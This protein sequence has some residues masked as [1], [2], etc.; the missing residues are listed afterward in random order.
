MEKLIEDVLEKLKE[1]NLHSAVAR[2][3]IVRTIM[4]EIRSGKG[5]F[6]NMSTID[7]G[8][9][10]VGDRLEEEKWV[11]AICGKPT[12]HI[13]YEYIGSEYNHLGC[14]LKEENI[15][16]ND[17]VYSGDL[18]KQAYTEMTSDGLPE[19]GDSQAVLESHKLAEEISS[20]TKDLGYIFESPDGG[21]TIYKRQVGES[22]RELVTKDQWKEYNRN[23]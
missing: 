7:D 4:K 2:Q 20:G 12:F 21:T 5:F 13:D 19:G 14:E 10:E 22:E 8:I 3:N 18:Q 16:N 11:C 9:P 6:L 1:S 17:Y 23:R 15:T